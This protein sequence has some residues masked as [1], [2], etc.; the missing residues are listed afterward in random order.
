MSRYTILVVL[1]I[2]F[3]I[4]VSSLSVGIRPVRASP[5]TIVV[6]DDYPTIQE[7][8]NNAN[9]GDTVFVKSGVYQVSNSIDT[10][11]IVINKSISLIGQDEETTIISDVSESA[12]HIIVINADNVTIEGFTFQYGFFGCRVMGSGCL[13]SNCKF[14]ENGEGISVE[15]YGNTINNNLVIGNGAGIVVQNSVNNV[16]N[17]IA[18]DNGLGIWIIGNGNT[19]AGNDMMNNTGVG[20]GLAGSCYYNIVT[21]NNINNNGWHPFDYYYGGIY[22][23]MGDSSN[24]IFLNNVSDNNVGIYLG[25]TGINE[26][27]HNSFINNSVQY[28]DAKVPLSVN[29]WD[30]GYPSGGN[31]WSDY[32]GT[33]MFSGPYQNL[34]S[35]DGI[36]DTPYVINGNNT[37]H[38]PLMKPYGFLIGDLNLDGKVDIKDIHIVAAAYGTFPGDPRWNPVADINKDGKVDIRDVSI[39]AKQ[40]GQHS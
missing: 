6:P 23:W 20:F 32:N 28:V 24:Q 7:A 27:Y 29:I 9:N 17:N 33:D 19:I 36:G 8:I 25:L 16:T 12:N 26:I 10:P 31:Y 13:I 4:C 34:T 14:I 15:G 5:R 38:Y 1:L 2:S 11:D 18:Q 30:N 21:G 3:L 39:V 35:S 40:Y 22:L 37:D